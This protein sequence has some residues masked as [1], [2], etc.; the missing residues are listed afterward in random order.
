MC[1]AVRVVGSGEMGYLR[2][3]IYFSVQ[4]GTLERYVKDRSRSPEELVN[5]DLGR[6]TVLPSELENKLAECCIIMEQ[7][8]CRL[9]R[10]DIKS[11]AFQLVTING[12]KR[13]FKKEKPAAAKEWL[14]SFLKRRPVL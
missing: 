7:R 3:S 11:V 4:T 8:Y 6:R 10:E 5:V 1:R 13:P 2:V 9:R 14:R 12:L